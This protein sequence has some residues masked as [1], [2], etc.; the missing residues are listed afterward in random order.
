MQ[1]M[2]KCNL[3]RSDRKPA[4]G[5]FSLHPFRLAPCL[6]LIVAASCRTPGGLPPIDLNEPGWKVSHGQALWRSSKTA[7][8]IAGDIIVAVRTE[9]STFVQFTKTPLPLVSART[10]PE[11]WWIEFVPE[12]RTFQGK[13]IAPVRLIWLHLGPAL[14]GRAPPKPLQFERSPGGEWRLGNSRTGEMLEGYLA[15]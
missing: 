9:G 4:C 12:K 8:Q 6:L 1:W 2:S 7:P 11:A 13:G 14:A 3:R 15:E 10:S 5:R